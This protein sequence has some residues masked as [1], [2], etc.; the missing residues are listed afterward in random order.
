MLLKERYGVNKGLKIYVEKHIPIGSG[1]GGPSSNAAAVLR[2]LPKI[3]GLTI[4]KADL[5]EMGKEIGAD[6]PLFLNDGPCI[7]KGIGEKVSPIGLP[8]LWYLIVYPDVV[9]KTPDV[10]GGIKIVLTKGENDI[11]LR[12]NFESV[13][14]VAGILENDLEKV[15]ILMCPTIKTLKKRLIEA[16]ALGAL[17]SG[18]GSSVFGIFENEEQAKKTLISFGNMKSA[19]IAHSIHKGE[20]YGH[21]R[22]QDFSGGREEG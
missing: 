12:K 9:L 6:V 16:G 18:S 13:Q 5:M 8:R 11:K 3:W 22:Y 10:Y 21:N 20:L 7:I 4:D 1:L 17:M 2:E 19:F 15:A 14:E